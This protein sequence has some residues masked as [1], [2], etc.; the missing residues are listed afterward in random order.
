MSPN[1][2]SSL[3]TTRTMADRGSTATSVREPTHV[4][5]EAL[6]IL[7]WASLSRMSDSNIRLFDLAASELL[8]FLLSMLS[9][10]DSAR[11]CYGFIQHFPRAPSH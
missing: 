7:A 9:L 1:V 10:L 2:T 6:V 8:L 4:L 11:L 3:E 5:F